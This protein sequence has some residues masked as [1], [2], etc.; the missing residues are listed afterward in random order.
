[1][2]QS[3]GPWRQGSAVAE[4]SSG[5]A[6]PSATRRAQLQRQLRKSRTSERGGGGDRALFAV[7]RAGASAVRI[8]ASD[9]RNLQLHD[10]LQFLWQQRLRAG[11]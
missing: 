9:R 2:R 7:S 11:G 6:E 4:H 5:P 10:E 8:A 3:D 1:V